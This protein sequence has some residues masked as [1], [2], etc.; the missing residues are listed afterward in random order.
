MKRRIS[1]GGYSLVELVV[2]MVLVSIVISNVYFFWRYMDRHVIR[3]SESASLQ[4]ESDRIVHQIVSSVKKS[5][6]LLNYDRNSIMMLG[7]TDE[8]TVSYSFSNDTLYRNKIAM[9]IL[10]PRSHVKDFEI[11]NLTEDPLNSFQF[12]FLEITVTLVNRTGFE[13]QA[14]LRVKSRGGMQ[15]LHPEW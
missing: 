3:H 10:T 1:T 7:E 14:T 11:K 12:L 13:S 2:A 15:D 8:D 4:S 5:S 6:T 9:S